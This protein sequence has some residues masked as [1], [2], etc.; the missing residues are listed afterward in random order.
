LLRS[1]LDR[2]IFLQLQA[3]SLAGQS[4]TKGIFAVPQSPVLRVLSDF[5]TVVRKSSCFLQMVSTDFQ[6]ALDRL[7][8][9]QYHDSLVQEAFDSWGILAD[10]TEGDM[11]VPD[12]S[13]ASRT[14]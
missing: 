2:A 9:L 10:I 14:K 11:W 4:C 6:E 7:G 1:L 13:K 3:R 8:L 12:L 5:R